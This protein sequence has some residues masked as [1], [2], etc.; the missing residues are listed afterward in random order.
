MQEHQEPDNGAAGEALL[1]GP[2][3]DED[4]LDPVFDDDEVDDLLDEHAAAGGVADE[5]PAD[6]LDED[7]DEDEDDDEDDED[8]PFTDDL[9]VGPFAQV[10]MEAA[11]GTVE[12]RLA[13]LEAAARS[14]AA[15]EVLAENRKVRRKVTAATTGAGAIGVVPLLLQ[16]LGA[17]DLPPEWAATASTAAAAIGALAAGWLTPEREPPL[18]TGEASALLALGSEDSRLE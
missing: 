7:G 10:G 17:V 13:R 5:A 3:P 6:D 2:P 15:A 4:L 18:P 9:Y 8:E 1:T 16:L 12:E 14:L 11:T